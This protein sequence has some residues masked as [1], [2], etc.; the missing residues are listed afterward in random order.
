MCAVFAIS[1][2]GWCDPPHNSFFERCCPQIE[3]VNIEFN[4]KI[5]SIT[6]SA[7]QDASS[8]AVASKSAT[9]AYGSSAALSASFSNTKTQQNSNTEQREFSMRIQVKAVQDTMPEGMAKVLGILVDSIKNKARVQQ[10]PQQQ[11]E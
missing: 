10:P 7:T 3:E 8:F 11:P 9:S 2:K 5:S 4:A 6:K 1:A